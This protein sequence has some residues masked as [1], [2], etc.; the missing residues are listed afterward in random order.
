V[1][2]KFNEKFYGVAY[3]DFDRNSACQTSGHGEMS[4]RIELPLKG[5]GTKQDPQRVFTNNI[6]VRFHPNLEMDGDEI[7]T[8]VCRYPPPI[9]LPVPPLPVVPT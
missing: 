5:C 7:I 9:T 3:A 8:I 4:Y 1:D 6:V 2:L